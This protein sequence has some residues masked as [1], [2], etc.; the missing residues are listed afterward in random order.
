MPDGVPKYREN[1]LVLVQISA[2]LQVSLCQLFENDVQRCSRQE[3]M[4][5][6][7]VLIRRC[8]VT[9]TGGYVETSE[10]PAQ[11]LKRLNSMK[12]S[13]IVRV[14][15]IQNHAWGQETCSIMSEYGVLG[16][17]KLAHWSAYYITLLAFP[18]SFWRRRRATRAAITQPVCKMHTSV[19]LYS[20]T[21]ALRSP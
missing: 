1:L 13:R 20:S 18:A 21:V 16:Q 2:A 11:I 8:G 10:N 5:C 14:S 9:S 12:Q 15:R 4:I 19:A 17:V 7:D 6:L 3:V